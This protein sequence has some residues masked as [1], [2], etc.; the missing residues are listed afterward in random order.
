MTDNPYV[1]CLIEAE[2][3]TAVRQHQTWYK[4]PFRWLDDEDL[5]FGY[6][7]AHEKARAFL[8]SFLVNR[9]TEFKALIRLMVRAFNG[10]DFERL[11]NRQALAVLYAREAQEMAKTATVHVAALLGINRHSAW[12]LLQRAYRAKMETSGEKFDYIDREYVSSWIPTEKQIQAKMRSKPRIC[13]HCGGVTPDG[14]KSLCFKCHFDL[15]T[16]RPDTWSSLTREWLQPEIRR[17]AQEHRVWAKNA[18]YLGHYGTVNVSDDE[19][20]AKA[21]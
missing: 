12:K 18:L 7:H 4:N 14:S 13:A 11:T 19:A 2:R 1:R 16:D 17:I 20:L 3:V 6:K 21:G 9:P 5:V 8:A 10:Y 15:R